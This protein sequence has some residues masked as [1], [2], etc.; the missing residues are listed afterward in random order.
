MLLHTLLLRRQSSWL[1]LFQRRL[2]PTSMHPFRHHL[3][4]FISLLFVS[5]V[6]SSGTSGCGCDLPVNQLP[7]GPSVQVTIQQSSSLNRTYLIHI[8]VTYNQSTATPLIFN[9]HGRGHTSQ[10]QERLTGFSRPDWNPNA[11]VIYPQGIN[12]T[13]QGDPDSI[14]VDDKEFVSDMITTLSNNY[15]LDDERIYATGKSNGGGFINLLACDAQLSTQIAAFAPVSA[16]IYIPG[17]KSTDCLGT[18]PQTLNFP[19]NPGRENVPILEFHGLQDQVIPYNGGP[20]RSSCLIS[21]LHWHDDWADN[22]GY[23]SAVSRTSLFDGNVIKLEYAP[24]TENQG[25]ITNYAINN[26]DHDW[27]STTPTDDS[28]YV[29]YIDASP[30]IIEFFENYTL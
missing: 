27:P 21:I 12:N 25:I 13:W 9:F 28:K 26:W 7:G 22:Q 2:L 14:N 11:I 19:C 15:C 1:E 5:V 8:P 17:V 18:I 23:G 24:G 20:R 4:L 29:T 6:T 10:Y 16:A 3:S 30:L